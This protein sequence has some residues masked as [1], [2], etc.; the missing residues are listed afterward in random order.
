MRAL[1]ADLVGSQ[2][3]AHAVVA[4]DA[5]ATVP[6]VA[7]APASRSASQ[8]L[9]QQAL[10]DQSALARR[11]SSASSVLHSR[12]QC[13]QPEST[14]PAA[15]EDP[16]AELVTMSAASS[17]TLQA[18]VDSFNSAGASQLE[19]AADAPVTSDA[20]PCAAPAAACGPL[21]SLSEADGM[22]A[23][24]E[25]RV[26]LKQERS[27]PGAAAS[28]AASPQA[29]GVQEEAQPPSG[30]TDVFAEL[31]GIS[32]STSPSASPTSRAAADV[33]QPPGGCQ[34]GDGAGESAGID[35][36]TVIEQRLQRDAERKQ[37]EGS[38]EDAPM[39]QIDA[40]SAALPALFDALADAARADN[41][42]DAL[43]GVD[44]SSADGAA[45]MVQWAVDSLMY[46]DT[47]MTSV[48][49]GCD[50]VRDLLDHMQ[51]A[52]CNVTVGVNIHFHCDTQ[53]ASVRKVQCC[54][55]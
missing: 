33:E 22:R 31:V 40:A 10:D 4:A 7:P 29:T 47:P 1:P 45:A 13:D 51:V 39:L 19:P 20:A 48:Q 36:R 52:A 50:R 34:L 11:C 24:R 21:A 5:Q 15:A 42:V 8:V 44:L 46:T 14:D 41:G 53:S 12:A 37:S 9:E 35:M 49:S 43:V 55:P 18:A 26:S 27:A 2:S 25:G 28:P 6:E 54:H 32:L 3:D 30:A 23:Q 38:S 17:P 16:F